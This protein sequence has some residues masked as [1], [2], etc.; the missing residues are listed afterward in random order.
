MHLG[1]KGVFAYESI[2]HLT[3]STVGAMGR[4]GLV[5]HVERKVSLMASLRK[6][7]TLRMNQVSRFT[8]F[9]EH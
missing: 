9:I 2:G 8:E 6:S 4:T 7:R 3:G 5:V 1:V